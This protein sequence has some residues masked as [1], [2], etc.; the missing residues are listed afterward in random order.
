MKRRISL[1]ALLGSSVASFWVLYVLATAPSSSLM[2]SS[3]LAITLAITA[4]ASLLGRSMPQAYYTFILLNGC[5]YALIGLA[6][7]LLRKGSHLHGH[8][9]HN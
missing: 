5:F 9:T 4:P 2:R 1:W 3:T 7:E 8:P 6:T